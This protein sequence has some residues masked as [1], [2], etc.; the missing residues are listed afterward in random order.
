MIVNVGTAN[1]AA[2]RAGVVE[3]RLSYWGLSGRSVG[4]ALWNWDDPAERAL[5]VTEQFVHGAPDGLKRRLRIGFALAIATWF[6]Y[7]KPAIILRRKRSAAALK[8]WNTR[9]LR[10]GVAV[11]NPVPPRGVP[12][13]HG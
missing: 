5:E 11:R 2:S 10:Q 8:G 4:M 9:R 12:E 13:K 6:R 1:L 7:T 3:L